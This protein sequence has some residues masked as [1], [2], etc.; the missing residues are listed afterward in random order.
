[1]IE[2]ICNPRQV[3]ILPVR[4]NGYSVSQGAMMPGAAGSQ[5]ETI[6]AT[7]IGWRC[8][9]RQILRVSGW[10]AGSSFLSAISLAGFLCGTVTNVRFL[11][12][13]NPISTCIQ[14][15]WN[16]LSRAFKAKRGSYECY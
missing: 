7:Q 10:T 2:Y 13:E 8:A 9:F 6:T 4:G 5:Q 16:R 11:F 12:C 15:R 1:L 14:E 3:S